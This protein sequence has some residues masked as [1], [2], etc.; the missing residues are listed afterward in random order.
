[1]RLDGVVRG[2]A[3]VHAEEVDIGP[4]TRIDGKLVVH[5][6][7]EPAVPEGAQIAGG[8]EFHQTDVATTSTSTRTHGTFTPSRTG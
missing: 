2:D 4:N 8:I 3:E 7:R 5:S 1:V 6:A